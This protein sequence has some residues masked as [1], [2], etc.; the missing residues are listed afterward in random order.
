MSEPITPS[1]L[2][3]PHDGVPP[4]A[5]QGKSL[6]TEIEHLRGEVAAMRETLLKLVE[7]LQQQNPITKE[8]AGL[9][10]LNTKNV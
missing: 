1:K 5:S 6:I 3:F 2:K 8:A 9:S 7:V 10:A 4:Q